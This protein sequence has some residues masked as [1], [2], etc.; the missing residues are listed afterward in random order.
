[1]G[2]GRDRFLEIIVITKFTPA[3]TT[4]GTRKAK[5]SMYQLHVQ[6]HFFYLK[7]FFQAPQLSFKHQPCKR[8]NTAG[9]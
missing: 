1:M 3:T 7:S 5:A 6:I 8:S 4:R 2:A 9:G